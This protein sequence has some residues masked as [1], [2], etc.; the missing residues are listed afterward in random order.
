M[1]NESNVTRLNPIKHFKTEQL[2][3]FKKK[4]KTYANV[5]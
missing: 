3:F 1:C 5:Q 4:K 2:S